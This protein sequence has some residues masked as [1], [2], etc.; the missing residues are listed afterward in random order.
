[1]TDPAGL[2]RARLVHHA[3]ATQN[4]GTLQTAPS[5]GK[6]DAAYESSD[7]CTS[8]SGHSEL[9]LYEIGN[10]R[11]C[12]RILAHRNRKSV[13][14]HPRWE[15]I[16]VYLCVRVIV[17]VCTLRICSL[18]E[19]LVRAP[20]VQY[21][22]YCCRRQHMGLP[23]GGWQCY[24]CNECLRV[25]KRERTPKRQTIYIHHGDRFGGGCW[26]LGIV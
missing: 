16:Y 24:D 15:K 6:V 4:G 2:R 13:V 17:L 3:I 18:L 8:A 20:S 7:G 21:G 22:M 19:G 5:T 23:T 11:L 10:V 9:L 14:Q 26:L 1:M 25:R 12:W